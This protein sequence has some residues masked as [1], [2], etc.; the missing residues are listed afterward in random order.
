MNKYFIVCMEFDVISLL[1]II[2]LDQFSCLVTVDVC[3][4]NIETCVY[5]I[6]LIDNF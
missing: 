1:L 4:Y 3:M 5:P 6:K 2:N